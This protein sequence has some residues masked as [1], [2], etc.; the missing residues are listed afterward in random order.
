VVSNRFV[1]RTC[2]VAAGV[3]FSMFLVKPDDPKVAK[4]PVFESD[5]PE[6]EAEVEEAPPP[7]KGAAGKR[8]A[9]PAAAKGKAKKAK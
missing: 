8:K 4:I 3:G 7:A 9:E 5:A 2:Q 6:V 1:P